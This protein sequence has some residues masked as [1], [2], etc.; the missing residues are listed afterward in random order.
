MKN[1][2]IIT[3]AT[4]FLGRHFLSQLLTE[5]NTSI[6]CLV[7]GTDQKA[8]FTRIQN[9]LSTPIENNLIVLKADIEKPNCDLDDLDYSSLKD[10]KGKKTF[11]HIAASLAWEPGKRE[12]IFRTNLIGTGN[13]IQLAYELNCDKFYYVSTAYTSGSLEGHIA[14]NFYDINNTTNNEYERSKL[15]AENKVKEICQFSNLDF[16]ILRP[17]IIVG[18]NRTFDAVGSTTGL[19]GFINQLRRFGKRLQD[20]K[21]T[22]R[23]YIKDNAKLSFIPINHIVDSMIYIKDHGCS[24]NIKHLT[25]LLTE[26]TATIQESIQ[27]IL[28]SLNLHNKIILQSTPVDEPSALEKILDRRLDFYK[29]YL[30]SDKEFNSTLP[31]HLQKDLSFEDLK[32]F[33]DAEIKINGALN[34]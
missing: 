16:T 28:T 9:L 32:K 31:P 20:S 19:Y 6:Y 7:R 29:S 5:E 2:H 24:E 33:I 34:E 12:Q 21:E 23:F 1:T 26:K 30:R 10:L 11:W 15:S 25:P 13:A 14:E 22:Y 17:A 8:S 3:G 4:G 18:D 27:Y